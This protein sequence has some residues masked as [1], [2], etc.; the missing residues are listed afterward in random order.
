MARRRLRKRQGPVKPG[1]GTAMQGII[2]A[3]SKQLANARLGYEVLTKGSKV[4]KAIIDN[5][6][7]RGTR[8]KKKD[9][10]EW[11][12]SEADGIKYKTH[13][14]SY[15]KSKIAKLTQKLSQPGRIYDYSTGG[16]SSAQ[17]NQQ[18]GIVSSGVGAN[19]TSLFQAL[20]NAVAFTAVQASRK[21][22]ITTTTHECEFANMGNSTLEMDLYICIDK[23]T[24][25]L[26]SQPGLIWDAAIA[27]EANDATLPA[28]AKTDLW[29]V[30]TVH[31]GWNINYW[32]KKFK[33]TLT[34]GENCKF[35]LRF[36]H[37]RV[38]DTEYLDEYQAIRGISHYIQVVA[39]GTL[40]D[41]TQT[42][43]VTAGG[44]TVTPGKLVWLVKRT[45]GGSV[46]ATL[47]R[48]NK[49]LSNELPGALATLFVQDEDSG[50][51]E[52]SMLPANYA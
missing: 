23:T 12:V 31:K 48:V 13:T 22:L 51:I 5:A 24:Q 38:L 7:G 32:T 42:L 46:L 41:S 3:T 34:P 2:G 52:D 39:R 49:Q 19:Y 40:G 11:Q 14:I 1:L 18:V 4:A 35:T 36:K 47:P 28:E 50:A 37:N 17:G 10:A 9:P 6:K 8:M 26:A 21:L 43:A 25:I 20:N 44:Q 16:V 33:C 29:T 30:P 27:N 15:K 45:F